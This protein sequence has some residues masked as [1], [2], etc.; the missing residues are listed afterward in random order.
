MPRPCKIGMKNEVETFFWRSHS[1]AEGDLQKKNFTLLSYQ[2]AAR[3]FN[4][5]SNVAL[6]VKVCPTLIWIMDAR[7]NFVNALLSCRG[8]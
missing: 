3:I 1:H 7:P 8:I 6:R 4:I 2:R 5:V